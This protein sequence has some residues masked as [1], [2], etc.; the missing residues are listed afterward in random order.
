M[1]V[2]STSDLFLLFSGKEELHQSS[3][4]KSDLSEVK[5]KLVKILYF[6]CMRFSKD[7]KYFLEHSKPYPHNRFVHFNFFFN[8]MKSVLK[9]ND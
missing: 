2:K 4:E 1:P 7:K 9:L 5:M 3:N 8:F 6:V